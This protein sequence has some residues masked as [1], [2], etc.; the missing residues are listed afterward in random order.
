MWIFYTTPLHKNYTKI[1]REQLIS[2]NYPFNCLPLKH[3]A[4]SQLPKATIPT[5]QNSFDDF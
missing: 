5:S 2:N 3:I 4:Y 1:V